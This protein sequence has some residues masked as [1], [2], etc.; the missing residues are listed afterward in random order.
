M[1]LAHGIKLALVHARQSMHFAYCFAGCQLPANEMRAR[2]LSIL[3]GLDVQL[4]GLSCL[5][6]FQFHPQ[7]NGQ[8]DILDRKAQHN[9]CVHIKI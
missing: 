3:N 4:S 6:D 8:L 2:G 1:D 9:I 5:L 7:L